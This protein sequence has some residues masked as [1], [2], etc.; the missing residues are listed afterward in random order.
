MDPVFVNLSIRDFNVL[1]K[2][3]DPEWNPS[4]TVIINNTLPKDPNIPDPSVYDRIVQKERDI[5]QAL[6]KLDMRI[7]CANPTIRAESTKEYRRYVLEF[8]E[9]IHQYPNYAS[10]RN[11]RAQGLRRLYGKCLFVSG[12]C[13]PGSLLSDADILD[14]KDDIDAKS[15][16]ANVVFSDLDE[17][18]LLLTP[19]TPRTPISPQAGR[20]LASAHTQRGAIY[21]LIAKF[22]ETRELDCIDG[23]R[24]SSWT[25]SDFEE[26]ASRDFAMGARY[27]DEIAKGLAVSTN[28]TAKLCGQMV[29]LAIKEEY[30]PYYGGEGRGSS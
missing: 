2:I 28:P 11:N 9:L 27:G 19:E 14:S 22:F 20:T 16:I 6:R 25:K 13:H 17:A 18:I 15:H 12:E 5:I 1:R 4:A 8:A 21:L 30:G 3:K 23:R 29:E 10:A 26:A 7:T 24:E